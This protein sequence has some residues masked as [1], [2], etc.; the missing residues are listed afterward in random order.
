MYE[1][2]GDFT[3]EIVVR[4]RR[5]TKT[6]QVADTKD[7]KHNWKTRTELVMVWKQ[8]SSYAFRTLPPFCM[9]THLVCDCLFSGN[10][11][12]YV[13]TRMQ[14]T[15]KACYP[16]LCWLMFQACHA[17]FHPHSTVWNPRDQN[18]ARITNKVCIFFQRLRPRGTLRWEKTGN[19]VNGLLVTYISHPCA[20][21]ALKCSGVAHA[22]RW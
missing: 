16:R 10:A 11:L 12:L 5:F 9:C 13:W 20:W 17:G 22:S 4:G 15:V 1:Y 6:L 3:S 7:S 14:S 21:C 19:C 8:G 18:E 2:K